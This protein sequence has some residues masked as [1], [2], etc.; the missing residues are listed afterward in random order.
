MTRGPEMAEYPSNIRMTAKRKTTQKD[1]AEACGVDQSTVVR[2]LRG[3][4]GVGKS[5]RE[6]IRAAAESMGYAPD[7]LARAMVT[8]RTKTIGSIVSGM[9]DEIF[10]Q[11]CEGWSLVGERG[12]VTTNY[13]HGRTLAREAEALRLAAGYKHDGLLVEP[14]SADV[15]VLNRVHRSGRPVASVAYLIGKA[16]F[17]QVVSDERRAYEKAFGLIAEK[18]YRLVD[19]AR[20]NDPEKGVTNWFQEN[21][22][23]H[24]RELAPACGLKIGEVFRLG[25]VEDYRFVADAIG[26]RGVFPCALVCHDDLIAAYLMMQMRLRQELRIP[27]QIGVLGNGNYELS[28]LTYP[29]LTT[30]ASHYGKMGRR[31]AEMLLERLDG[32]F[33]GPGRVERIVSDMEI[34]QSL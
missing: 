6:E 17:D 16:D 3:E 31:A 19:Y 9:R 33:D 4:P 22:E 10:T 11:L 30:V 2:A 1:I 7:L 13:F 5:K 34:R 23:A 14:A 18:G 24:F 12:Y 28:L 21:R 27:E 32:V 8:G 25:G 15:S 26:E 29:M 20:Y